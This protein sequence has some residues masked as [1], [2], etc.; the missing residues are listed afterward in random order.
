[1]KSAHADKGLKNSLPANID[2]QIIRRKAMSIGTILL[3]VFV[4]AFLGVIPI[5]PHS[6]SWGYWPGGG[7]GIIAIILV[8]LL[9]T[10]RL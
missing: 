1:M 4:L 2:H 7:L 8:I 3:I 6:H 9:L 5:W 10:G